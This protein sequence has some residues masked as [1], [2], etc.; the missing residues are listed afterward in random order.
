MDGI[1]EEVQAPLGCRKLSDGARG[2]RRFDLSGIADLKVVEPG[3][4]AVIVDRPSK[5]EFY[6]FII[7]RR[8][9]FRLGFPR[10]ILWF[11][12]RPYPM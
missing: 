12:P 1:R 8:R 3:V 2:F 10:S 5:R 9:I 4:G 6:I 11:A 7:F